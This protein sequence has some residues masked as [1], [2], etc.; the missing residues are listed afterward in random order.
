MNCGAGDLAVDCPVGFN[1]FVSMLTGIW[2]WQ[3][4]QLPQKSAFLPGKGIR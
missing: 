3:L 2:F 1:L 4:Q